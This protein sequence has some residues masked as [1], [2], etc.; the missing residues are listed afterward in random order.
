MHWAEGKRTG[1]RLIKFRRRSLCLRW[2]VGARK[3]WALRAG[4]LHGTSLAPSARRRLPR[5]Q[6]QGALAPRRALIGWRAGP[7]ICSWKA[8]ERSLHLRRPQPR[9]SPAGG[10]EGDPRCF[11]QV[12]WGAGGRKLSNEVTKAAN[13]TV[14]QKP[15]LVRLPAQVLTAQTE[16]F[17]LFAQ[18]RK[19][20]LLAPWM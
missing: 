8:V 9:Q 14:P 3:T 20:T 13:S 5:R 2:A 7:P 17:H 16:Q 11:V 1:E 4:E 10:R 18:S 19:A 6:R 15:F 12:S